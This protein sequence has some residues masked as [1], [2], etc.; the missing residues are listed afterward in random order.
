MGRLTSI[1]AKFCLGMWSLPAAEVCLL[2]LQTDSQRRCR[3]SSLMYGIIFCVW[4]QCMLTDEQVKIHAPGNPTERRYGGWLGGSILASLGTFHQLWI[5]REEWQVRL[6]RYV[7]GRASVLMWLPLPGAWQGHCRPE[8]QIS[9][10]SV[11]DRACYLHIS[12]VAT[13]ST[14]A[15]RVLY[16]GPTSFCA[17]YV[18]ISRIATH[19]RFPRFINREVWKSSYGA[20]TS[21]TRCLPGPL[22]P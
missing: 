20:V 10:P 2:D 12:S 7:D 14:R 3:D 8:V 1:Y 11:Q 22:V 16:F 19:T 21:M 15:A 17:L 4:L 5:S 9:R 13:S 18:S 6:R